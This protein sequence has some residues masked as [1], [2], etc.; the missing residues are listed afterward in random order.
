MKNKLEVNNPFKEYLS[1]YVHND[2]SVYYI[3]NG[4][5]H[6]ETKLEDLFNFLL[7]TKTNPNNKVWPE[8]IIKSMNHNKNIENKS[9]FG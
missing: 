1:N 5:K 2:S 6:G 3:I 7:S 8:C 9:N 4:T